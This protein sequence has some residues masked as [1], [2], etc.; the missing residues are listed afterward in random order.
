MDIFGHPMY[1]MTQGQDSTSANKVSLDDCF[2]ILSNHRRRYLLHYLECH[3]G[4]TDI[5]ELARRIAAWENNISTEEVRYEER[6][7]VYTSLQQVHLP[8]MDKMGVVEFDDQS[9]N[10][11]LGP[12]ADEVDVYM[13]IVRGNNIPWSIFYLG[14]AVLNLGIILMVS[15]TDAI[16]PISNGFWLAIFS[17]TTFLVASLAHIYINRVEMRLGNSSKPPELAE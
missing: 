8:R 13:E 7:R 12:A 3:N 15:L 10:V 4:S 14:S 5:G 16:L 1:M 6:K 17:V 9:G 2:D 11:Q